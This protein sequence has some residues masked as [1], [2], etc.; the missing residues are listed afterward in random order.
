MQKVTII[1]PYKEDRGWL[2]Q[3]VESATSQYASTVVLSQGD[4]NVCQNL[5]KAL[6]DVKTEFWCQLDEDDM[7]TTNSV[8]SRLAA[9]GSADFVHGR[10]ENLFEGGQR[11]PYTLTEPYTTFESCLRKNGIFGSSALYRTSLLDK[12]GLWDESLT[13]GEEWE[14][15]LRLLQGGC[16]L[17]FCPDIVYTYRRHNKQKSLGTNVDQAARKRVHQL[18]RERYELHK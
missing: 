6:V 2:D 9:I 7:L 13:T 14:Y 15:H 8:R 1:I 11:S 4:G 5:N 3:A 10:A 18:I 16:R 12:F 17:A